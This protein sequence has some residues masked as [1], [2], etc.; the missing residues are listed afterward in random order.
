MTLSE[1]QLSFSSLMTKVYATYMGVFA[2]IVAGLLLA[3][4]SN[5][6]SLSPNIL[7]QT[8]L[9]LTAPLSVSKLSNLLNTSPYRRDLWIA[10]VSSL[11]FILVLADI[12]PELGNA[13]HAFSANVDATM[14]M[15]MFVMSLFV[16]SYFILTAIIS[17]QMNKH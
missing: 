7:L 1:D 12:F 3:V 9:V 10:G 14:I 15:S 2:L 8:F 17:S 6:F 13:Y 16:Y 5:S 11:L 4:N